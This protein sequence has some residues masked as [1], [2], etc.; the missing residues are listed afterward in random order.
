MLAQVRSYTLMGIDALPLSV[1]VDVSPGQEKTRIVGLPDAAVKE[2]EERVISALRNSGF[3]RPAGNVLIN[4]APADLRKQGSALDLPIALGILLA[5]AQVSGAR[6][7][8]HAFVGELALDG[9]VRPVPGSLA[10]AVCAKTEKKKG[11]VLPAE[12]ADEAGVVSGIDV[13]PVRHIREAADFLNGT[14]VITP[15]TTDVD[16]IFSARHEY[17]PDFSEVRGQGQV[18]RALTIAAAGGHNVLM[19]GPPGTGK[20]MLASRLPGILPDMTFEEALETTAILSVTM[21]SLCGGLSVARIIRQPPWPSS[22]EGRANLQIPGKSAW[23]TTA[24]CSS[25]N[26]PSLTVRL[27]KF[28]VNPSK[29]AWYT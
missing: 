13:L 3:R 18:K 20:T 5:S 17:V 27:W 14:T 23:P 10:M 6:A 25:M 16:S 12:N 2:S 19:I 1:E 28:C 24:C 9:T 22:G 26:F 7:G 4:L 15:H 21:P 29:R 8:E 11:I